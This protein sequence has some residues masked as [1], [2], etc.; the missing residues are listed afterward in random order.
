M[1]KYN[2]KNI[3]YYIVLRTDN[4]IIININNID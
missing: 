2:N 3:N 4:K 1:L